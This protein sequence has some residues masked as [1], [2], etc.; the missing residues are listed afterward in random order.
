MYIY[1]YIFRDNR[2]PVSESCL[3]IGSG[4]NE[5]V[6][7]L[8]FD[9]VPKSLRVFHP[10]ITHFFPSPSI[11]RQSSHLF[12]VFPLYCEPIECAQ[13]CSLTKVSI[14]FW[15]TNHMFFSDPQRPPFFSAFHSNG[16]ELSERN[17]CSLNKCR[18]HVLTQNSSAYVESR[19]HSQI[20]NQKI[21]GE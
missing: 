6:Q 3:S 17:V 9:Q 16:S 13:A 10:Q 8:F 2:H 18:I 5:L 19:S 7:R 12:A 4:M 15:T 21:R 20:S 1:I 14:V 11:F